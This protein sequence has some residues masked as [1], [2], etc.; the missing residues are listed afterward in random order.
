MKNNQRDLALFSK[1]MYGVAGNF[2]GIISDDD[3][4]LRFEVLQEFS[5]DQITKAG[6]WL[7]RNREQTFPAVPT[8]KEF[9]DAIKK[10]DGPSIQLKAD[11]EAD[12]VLETL[13]E[14][15]RDAEALF[16]DEITRYIMTKRWTFR[17]LDL[18]A[19]DDPGLK[20]WRK[21]FVQSYQDIEKDKAQGCN[22]LCIGNGN[23][24]LKSIAAVAVKRL[25]V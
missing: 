17:K 1:V 25:H 23:E 3:L 16:H 4:S 5:I 10:A 22:T 15:G 14:W 9:I 24:D 19:V 6:T 12:K 11:I 18:M 13:K 8:T 7:L 20:W 2:G 21:E